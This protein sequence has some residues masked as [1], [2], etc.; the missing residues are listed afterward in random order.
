MFRTIVIGDVHGCID[1][2]KALLDTAEISKADRI[3]FLGDLID[4]GP[5]PAAVVALAMAI[6]AE[7]VMGN[8]EEKAL[9]W[10]RHEL[11]RRKELNHYKNPMRGI[12]QARLDQ[13]NKIPDKHWDWISAWPQFIHLGDDYVGVH[14]GC[15]PDIAVERQV[16]NELMR[17]RYVK[18]TGDSHGY[19]KFKMASLKP[20]GEA[21][22]PKTGEKIVHWTELWSG[23]KN[24]IYGHYVWDE[25]NFTRNEVTQAT[26]WGIDTGCVHGGKLTALELFP[27]HS[28]WLHQVT[29]F[30]TYAERKL[31]TEE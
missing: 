8:H 7:C 31:W 3:I 17:L 29:A 5:D 23:P 25:V 14:A 10:R 24:I 9:R 2:L 1:E 21:P 12:D 26:T 20:T 15:M 18:C 19:A 11:R 22:D 30:K 4:R 28:P 13:W 16:P 6:G 27:D